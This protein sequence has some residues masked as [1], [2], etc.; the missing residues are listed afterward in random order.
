[1]NTL[2]YVVCVSVIERC[3]VS[4]EGQT[5]R[6]SDSPQSQPISSQKDDPIYVPQVFCHYFRSEPD[7]SFCPIIFL[8]LLNQMSSHF[9]FHSF[10]FLLSTHSFSHH[11]STSFFSP[12]GPSIKYQRGI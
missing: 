11:L 2:L 8:F 3:L 12:H 4:T 9:I 1:M 6:L 5:Q 10:A 7:V